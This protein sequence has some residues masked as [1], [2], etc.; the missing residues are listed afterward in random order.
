MIVLSQHNFIRVT[1][2][3]TL[4]RRRLCRAAAFSA[5]GLIN[6]PEAIQP[7]RHSNSGDQGSVSPEHPVACDD[8]CRLDAI[9]AGRR[10]RQ[11]TERNQRMETGRWTGWKI[12]QLTQRLK[13]VRIRVIGLT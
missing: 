1:G 7:E 4:C 12:G 8:L 10:Q 2:Q 6:N 11:V 13:S 3:A 5:R 9:F